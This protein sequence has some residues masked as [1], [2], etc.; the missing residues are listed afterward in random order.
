MKFAEMCPGDGMVLLRKT[1]IILCHTVDCKDL[2]ILRSVPAV[3][4]QAA[5]VL[6]YTVVVNKV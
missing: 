3:D 1:R 5:C 6:R 2:D 4:S